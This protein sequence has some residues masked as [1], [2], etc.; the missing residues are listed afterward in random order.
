MAK[1][2][3]SKQEYPG[4]LIGA[5]RRRIRQAVTACARPHDLS[6]QQFWVLVAIRAHQGFS[7]SELADRQRLD[8]PTASRVV[9]ALSRRKLVRAEGDPEDRRRLR[10]WLTPQGSSLAAELTDIANAVRAAVVEGMTAS[11]LDALR[12]GLYRVIENMDRF[13]QRRSKAAAS[14]KSAKQVRKQSLGR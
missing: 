8:Q 3:L 5:A 9:L 1:Q 10:L 7:L 14:G 11:E 2:P 4:L 12:A 13:E 6:S